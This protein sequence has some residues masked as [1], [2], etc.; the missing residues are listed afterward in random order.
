M[1]EEAVEA[2]LIGMRLQ[3]QQELLV[4]VEVE[5]EQFHMVI[6]AVHQSK[7][8]MGLLT[9]VVVVVDQHGMVVHQVV[10]DWWV[11]MVVQE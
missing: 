4:Q 10:K 2:V 6:R 9:Q 8:Q 7:E 11:L 3:E 1:Q 5:Q